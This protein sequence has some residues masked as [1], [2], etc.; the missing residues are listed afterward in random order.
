MQKEGGHQSL[1]LPTYRNVQATP[2]LPSNEQSLIFRGHCEQSITDT[3]RL[4]MD[5]Q[6]EVY[7]SGLE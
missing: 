3:L 4:C 7:L 5:K 1:E 6:D 2:P